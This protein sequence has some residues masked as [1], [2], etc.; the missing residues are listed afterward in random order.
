VGML[1][2][3][4]TMSEPGGLIAATAVYHNLTL[5]SRNVIDFQRT[6]VKTLNP[7]HWKPA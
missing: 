7:W 2:L 5:V 1:S 4:Q 3:G 6:G